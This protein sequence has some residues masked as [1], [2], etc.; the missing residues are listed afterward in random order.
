MNFYELNASRQSTRA[1]DTERPV[2]DEKLD[3]IIE[4]A[5]LSP[6]ACNS[7]PYF[8]TVCRGSIAREVGAACSGMGLNAFARDA[9][10]L[11]V[12]SEMPYNK[13]AKLGALLKGNDYRSI[14]V[15]I[16]A[17]TIALAA[18]EEGLGSCILGWFDEKKIHSLCDLSGDVRLVIAIGY[19]KDGA[20]REKKRKSLDELSKK[21]YD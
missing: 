13:S 9:S 4:A 1:F 2:E 12:I 21:L 8:F 17:Q 15:G 20:I 3:R 10:A 7:Q 19:A 11:I 14:D 5:R 18:T 16:A 6:S